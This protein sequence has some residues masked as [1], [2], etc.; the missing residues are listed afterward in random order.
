M[1]RI[2]FIALPL[3]LLFFISCKEEIPLSLTQDIGKIVIEGEVSNDTAAPL[4]KISKSTAFDN[5][6]IFQPYDVDY[7]LLT[8]NIGMVDTMRRIQEG[9]YQAQSMR[10]VIGNTYYLTVKDGTK[11]YTSQ[12]TIPNMPIIDSAYIFYFLTQDNRNPSVRF[13]DPPDEV[14]QYR[15]FT[16]VN[17]KTPTNMYVLEDK[18]VNGTSWRVS[19]F[20][21]NLKLGDT[22]E[23][24]FLA[25]DRP[26]Y[27]YW[28]ILVQ[29]QTRTAGGGDEVAPVN[30]PSNITGGVLGYFSAHARRTFLI[31]PRR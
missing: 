28:Q 6:V 13:Q 1:N 27:D 9:I 7:V 16:R 5:S 19:T 11:M 18:L 15:Y 31:I 24:V 21:D 8:D 3:S 23:F 25:I 20:R 4:V 26:N 17:R 30:P 29:N 2:K 10:G 22:A 12:S 14:N